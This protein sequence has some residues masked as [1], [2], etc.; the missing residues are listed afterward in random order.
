MFQ[1]LHVDGQL[2]LEVQQRAGDTRVAI[3]QELPDVTAVLVEGRNAGPDDCGG[4][5]WL[6]AAAL[7][8]S[9]PIADL[10]TGT[11]FTVAN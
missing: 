5:V 8:L 9:K 11:Q 7:D 3:L 4:E 10:S 2:Q 1:V 6:P